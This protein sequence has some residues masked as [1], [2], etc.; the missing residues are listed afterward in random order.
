LKALAA[1]SLVRLLEDRGWMLLRVNGSHYIYG[2]TGETARIS[3]PFH[4][5]KPLKA[6]LQRHLMKIAKISQDEL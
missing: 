3:V 6:G 4:G 1:K 2:K 5:V